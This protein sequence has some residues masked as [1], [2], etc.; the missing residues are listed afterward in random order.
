M[1]GSESCIDWLSTS[2]SMGGWRFEVQQAIAIAQLRRPSSS[3]TMPIDCRAYCRHM[4]TEG[5]RVSAHLAFYH[6]SGPFSSTTRKCTFSFVSVAALI[7]AFAPSRG[8][9]KPL[10]EFRFVPAI[11]IVRDRGSREP[12]RN[13]ATHRSIPDQTQTPRTRHSPATCRNKS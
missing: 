8:S 12:C 13:S 6:G 2:M 5:T 9:L 7:S 1:A 3:V 11:G 4:P 10:Y